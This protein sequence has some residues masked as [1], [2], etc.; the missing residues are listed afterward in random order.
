STSGLENTY[1]AEL[2]SIDTGNGFRYDLNIKDYYGLASGGTVLS[3]DKNGYVGIGTTAPK[4]SLHVTGL[5]E[6]ADNA[7]AIAGG[8]TAGAFYRTGDLLKV[9]H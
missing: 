7:A 5:A 9:V 4:A 6:Y 2:V 3:L 1:Y 8:L